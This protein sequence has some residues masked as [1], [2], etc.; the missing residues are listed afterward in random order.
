MAWVAPV[1]C[2][3]SDENLQLCCVQW[4]LPLSLK[5]LW[6]HWRGRPR[7]KKTNTRLSPR[8]EHQRWLGLV[9][10]TRSPTQLHSAGWDWFYQPDPQLS[11]TCSPPPVADAQ[12]DSYTSS[13][14]APDCAETAASHA[15]CSDSGRTAQCWKAT[16]PLKRWKSFY[17][18]R[19]H[20]WRTASLT[21]PAR[22]PTH[23]SPTFLL[24]KRISPESCSTFSSLTVSQ[25]CG[26]AVTG[27]VGGAMTG[28]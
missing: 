15:G 28:A 12:A 23:Q 3:A 24:E 7:R 1:I 5:T 19:S 13:P 20:F 6:P 4:T 27:A 10:P 11:C 14:V 26:G 8:S 2:E 18:G 22:L 17:Q 21:D 9:L 16:F 25:H